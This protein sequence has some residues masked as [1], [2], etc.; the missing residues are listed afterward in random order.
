M[1]ETGGAEASFTVAMDNAN[2]AKDIKLESILL[3][4][5]AELVWKKGDSTLA[6]DL[7]RQALKRFIAIKDSITSNLTNMSYIF[8]S[9]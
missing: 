4:C 2:K 7:H 8:D 5:L 6:L 3:S 9:R 1:A